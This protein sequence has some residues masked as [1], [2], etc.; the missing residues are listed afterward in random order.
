MKYLGRVRRCQRLTKQVY[1]SRGIKHMIFT[2]ETRHKKGAL[3][4]RVAGGV[5]RRF[6]LRVVK[7]GPVTFGSVTSLVTVTVVETV[8]LARESLTVA[9]ARPLED[10]HCR[11]LKYKEDCF[12]PFS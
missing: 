10:M 11:Y 6:A 12:T 8:T 7:L 3:T 2:T 4:G 9:V 1:P 5:E